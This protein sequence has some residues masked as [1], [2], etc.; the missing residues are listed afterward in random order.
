MNT[1]GTLRSD[2]AA[3]VAI[4]KY[5]DANNLRIESKKKL[6]K[7]LYYTEGF[8][9]AV[10]GTSISEQP[11]KAW[12]DGPVSP[13]ARKFAEKRTINQLR[14][15][16]WEEVSESLS[17]TTEFILQY[18]VAEKGEMTSQDLIDATHLED[19]WIN[20]RGS[21]PASEPSNVTIPRDALITYFKNQKLCGATPTELMIA[22]S[23]GP[24][25]IASIE[26]QCAPEFQSAGWSLV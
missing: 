22:Y 6:Q 18:V 15:I 9:Q 3:L 21:L 19:P 26:S 11:L 14:E 23:T 13:V 7:L 8:H 25:E 1:T 4:A 17:G 12:K 2:E 20:A 24:N 5:L 10:F 16:P